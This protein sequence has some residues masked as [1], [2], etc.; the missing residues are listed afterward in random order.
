MCKI[1]VSLDISTS[2]YKTLVKG[3]E[4]LEQ[5]LNYERIQKN[6]SFV[7]IDEGYFLSYAINKARIELESE[8]LSD[9]N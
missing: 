8:A 6:K 7:H 3:K 2:D 4:L 1:N 9:I 5:K